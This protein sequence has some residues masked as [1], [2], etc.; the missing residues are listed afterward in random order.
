MVTKKGKHPKQISN[1]DDWQVARSTNVDLRKPI[2]LYPLRSL[3]LVQEPR[4]VLLIAFKQNDSAVTGQGVEKDREPCAL[5]VRV[6]GADAGPDGAVVFDAAL[7]G[8]GD[9]DGIGLHVK[10][11]AA[12]SPAGQANDR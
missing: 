9:E 1:R 12:T 6:G 7:H 3:G 10:K 2:N 8:V 5:F 4:V 11:R